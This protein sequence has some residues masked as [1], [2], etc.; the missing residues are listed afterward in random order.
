MLICS[1]LGNSVHDFS[2]LHLLISQNTSV[3]DLFSGTLQEPPPPCSQSCILFVFIAE[4][5]CWKH[6]QGRPV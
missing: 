4:N 3:G 1:V 5:G 2:H 6:F